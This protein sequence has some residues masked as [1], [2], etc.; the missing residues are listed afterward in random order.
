[1]LEY[2]NIPEN[3]IRVFYLGSI[4]DRSK[5]KILHEYCQLNNIFGHRSFYIPGLP[6]NDLDIAHCWECNHNKWQVL[7]EKGDF[8]IFGEC[9]F[10]KERLWKDYENFD[11]EDIKCVRDKNVFVC[12]PCL[13]PLTHNKNIELNLTYNCHNDNEIH[14]IFKNVKYVDMGVPKIIG[15]K[16]VRKHIIKNIFYDVR[17]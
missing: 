11:D 7:T 12:G 2:F 17:E 14:E 4:V 10:C 15:K 3:K 9:Y 1:M 5:R 13:K 16:S 8:N 6:S